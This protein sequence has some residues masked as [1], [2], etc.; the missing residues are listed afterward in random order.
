MA[1][2]YTGL[3]A[4]D[5][6]KRLEA[7][8]TGL[9]L[10]VCGF[11]AGIVISSLA[12]SFI[13]FIGVQTLTTGPK[14]IISTISQGVGFSVV[15]VGFVLRSGYDDLIALWW[16]TWRDFGWVVVGFVALLLAVTGADVVLTQFGVETAQHQIQQIGAQNPELLLSMIVLSFLVIGPGEELLF[17]GAIQG[18]LRRVYAPIPAILVASA[19]FSMPHII[20]VV[21]TTSGTFAYLAVVFVLGIILGSIYE[22]T[23]NLLVPS[24]VHGAYDGLTFV[25]IYQ[26]VT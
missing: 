13:Q 21:G 16:P 22:R 17:R 23:N 3:D 18:I 12:L 4:A 2:E 15:V 19:L 6:P 8:T 7:I 10:V 14:Y 25:M 24:V 1:S 11:G 20:S 26:Q 9:L 5:W